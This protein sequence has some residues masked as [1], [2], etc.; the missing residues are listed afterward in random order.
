MIRLNLGNDAEVIRFELPLEWNP[1]DLTGLTLAIEDKA[2]NTLAAAAAA[3]LYTATTLDGAVSATDSSITLA[4]GADALNP[5][6]RILVVGAG[7]SEQKTVKGYASLVAEVDT[8]FEL[9]YSDGD[10]VY[11]LFATIEVDISDTDDFPAGQELLLIWTPAGTG[12]VQTQEAEVSAYRQ[13]DVAGLAIELQDV[14]PRAYTGLTTPRYRLG[15]IAV[16]AQSDVRKL[17]LTQDPTCE[18]NQIRDMDIIR[19]AVAAQCAVLWTL[20]GDD[21]LTEERKMY[22]EQLATEI[23]L[24]AKM[25]IWHDE[26]DDGVEDS[27]EERVHPHYFCKGW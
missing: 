18:L 23:D 9:G 24:L 7:G 5:G 11:G 12:G 1:A 4:D 22:R 20:N 10:D 19:P 16:R 17:L 8:I 15:R 25:P 27:G 6:D 14:Y 3:T 2:G 13:I 26:D 21:E